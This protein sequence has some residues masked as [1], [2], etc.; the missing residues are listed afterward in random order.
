MLGYA[1]LSVLVAEPCSGYDLAKRFDKS[2]EGSIGFFWNASYQQIY[3]ELARLEEKGRISARTVH[4]ENRPDKRIYSVTETGRHHLREWIGSRETAS[5]PKDDLLVKLFAGYLVSDAVILAKL[6]EH[7]RQHRQR[8]K[9]Y[10]EIERKY[11]PDRR[12]MSP[13]ERSHYI[14]LRRGIHHERGWLDWALEIRALFK[15]EDL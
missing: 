12:S 2:I 7:T 9:I 14:T 6:E 13:V 3:R 10:E 4:Q 5:Y 1:I 15:S 11:F 8:L